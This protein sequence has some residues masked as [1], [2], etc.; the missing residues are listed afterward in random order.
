MADSAG[1]HPA[2]ARCIRTGY[3]YVLPQAEYKTCCVC[4]ENIYLGL[5]EYYDFGT[6]PVCEHCRYEYIGRVFGCGDDCYDFG[7]TLVDDNHEYAFVR[8]HYL[9]RR[10][11]DA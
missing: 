9:K 6:G 3:P 1:E 5:D 11:D 10:E 8:A 2:I 4:G 7:G